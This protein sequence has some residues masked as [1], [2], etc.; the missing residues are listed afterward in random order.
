[1][2]TSSRAPLGLRAAGLFLATVAFATAACSGAAAGAGSP[3]G[4]AATTAATPA[5]TPAGVPDTGGSTGGSVAVDPCGLVANADADALLGG[6]A[7]RTGPTEEARGV[8]CKWNV[9]GGPDLLVAVW[10][11]KQ[12]YGPDMTNPGWKPV[13]NLGDQSYEDAATQTVGFIKGTTVVVLYV[14][15]LDTIDLAALENLA[16]GAAAKL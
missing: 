15:A 7:V 5:S 8:A 6:S 4:T 14:P 2:S 11:G 9:P 16:R 1:M 10:Q 12:F 3:T 13:S